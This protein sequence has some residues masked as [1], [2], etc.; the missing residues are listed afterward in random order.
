MEPDKLSHPAA[1]AP[2]PTRQGLFSLWPVLLRLDGG[3]RHGWR[4]SLSCPARSSP[5]P[6]ACDP[7]SAAS[8][9]AGSGGALPRPVISPPTA[10]VFS[11]E[12]IKANIDMMRYVYAPRLG[13]QARH[14]Q[15]AHRLD[16]PIGRLALA[17]SIALTPGSLVME[18]EGD[19]PFDPLARHH[20][21]DAKSK[22]ATQA[23]RPVREGIWRRSLAETIVTACGV[24][25]TRPS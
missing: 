13:D 5:S 23:S 24:L 21:I 6:I 11:V 12:L 9:G 1:H 8:A 4:S 3:Q 17:N 15:G 18:F 25:I 19:D 2:P 16:S 7:R 20:G 14:R 10:L 22:I